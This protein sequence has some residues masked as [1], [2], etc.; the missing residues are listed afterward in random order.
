MCVCVCVCVNILTQTHTSDKNVLIKNNS[1]WL[2]FVTV[3]TPH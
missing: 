1:P 3:T 2:V